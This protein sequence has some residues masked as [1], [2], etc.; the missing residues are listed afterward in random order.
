MA[1][2]LR[3]PG[4]VA[5]SSEAVL[6]EW[7]VEP[8]TTV[9]AGD[10][11][12]T[13]ETEKA[14]V[15]IEADAD[16]VL[17]RT[18]LEPSLRVSPGAALAL[19]ADPD[20]TIHDVDAALASLGAPADRSSNGADVPTT[21][22]ADPEGGTA[23][24]GDERPVKVPPPVDVE[25]SDARRVFASPLAR[26]LAR[27]HGLELEAIP[28]TGPRGRVLKRDVEAA[29]SEAVDRAGTSAAKDA[30]TD[31]ASHTAFSEVPHT[32][33]RR[34]IATTLTRSK[35]EVP[36]FY[37]RGSVR[38]DRLLR[39]REELN[40]AGAPK[41]SLNDFVVKAVAHSHVRVPALN[42]SWTPDAVRSFAS[43]D[44]AIA[45]AI[46]DGL[47]T[48]VLR[49]ADRLS[50]RA[51]AGRARTLVESAR[52]GGLRQHQ[53]EGGT[54]AVTNLGMYDTEEFAAIIN[55]PQSS[56]LAVGAAR[57][58]PVVTAK[59][60]LRAA[61]VMRVTL[62]VDHRAVDGAQAAAWMRIFRDALERPVQLLE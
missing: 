36:H 21:A 45:V 27:Q 51:V 40:E 48:P 50:L 31:G 18:L 23:N 1:Q 59:G 13:V 15:D 58:E 55:P 11:V 14:V 61:T 25:E 28:G 20:E 56:I 46:D 53:L 54:V 39:L 3:M 22:A 29:R 47:V 4:I 35:Q 5:N 37:V 34:A 26:R 19:I 2:L 44:V 42:V 17:V 33:M 10:V 49:G 6:R 38:V 9:A 16:G 30:V 7:A 12:A 41:V 8:G 52:A 60:K 62:S 57:R 43:V 32:R 24:T